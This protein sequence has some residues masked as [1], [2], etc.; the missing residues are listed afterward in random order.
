MQMELKASLDKEI[1][2]IE[3]ITSKLVKERVD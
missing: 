2:N 1:P 3:E